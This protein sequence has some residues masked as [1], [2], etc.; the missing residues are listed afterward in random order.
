[1]ASGQTGHH[2]ALPGGLARL[3]STLDGPARPRPV[4]RW[5]PPF[6]GDIDMRIDADGRWHYG[7]TPIGRLALVKLFASILRKDPD[8]YV[9][10]TPV[11]RVGIAVAD[12]PFLAVEMAVDD[13][14]AAAPAGGGE[15]AG[16]A[17]PAPV[18]H[19]R[20]NLDDVVAVGAAHPLRFASGAAGGL[21]PYVH[22]RGDLWARLTR[23]TMYAL[24]ERGEERVV[25]GTAMFGVASGADFFPITPM[26]RIHDVA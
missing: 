6:C 15:P 7:G 19:L 22:V 23:A 24:V 9:L 18:L 2:I 10:V 21:M 3:F 14:G 11:E 25:A 4:E 13:S 8:R 16:G 26:S 1:M 5:N 12:V 20:T 17:Q